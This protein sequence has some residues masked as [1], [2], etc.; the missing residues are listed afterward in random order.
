MVGAAGAMIAE[1]IGFRLVM[2]ASDLF[3]SCFSMALGDYLS[4]FFLKVEGLIG[5]GDGE[6]WLG[7][8]GEF[9]CCGS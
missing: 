8:E 3:S 5:S 6:S 7:I 9:H 2:L 4:F 1:A